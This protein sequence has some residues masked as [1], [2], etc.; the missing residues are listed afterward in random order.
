VNADDLT[1]KS[2]DY[3]FVDANGHVDVVEIKQ[4]FE[5]AIMTKVKYRD[6]YIPLRELSGT[7]MQIEKYTYYL[8]IWGNEVRIYLLPSTKMSFHK[9]LKFT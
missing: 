4:P 9:G 8:N 5:H 7:V 6:N 3:L 1:T 2:L